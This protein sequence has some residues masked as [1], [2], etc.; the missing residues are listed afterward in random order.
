MIEAKF[1]LIPFSIF[2]D[3][4][5]P[6]ETEEDASWGHARAAHDPDDDWGSG[7]RY[8]GFPKGP[9]DSVL[10]VIE[11]SVVLE[12]GLHFDFWKIDSLEFLF[13]SQVQEGD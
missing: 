12:P 13:I 6:A 4:E 7:W 1:V 8:F 3:Y 2:A 10:V 9:P 5:R 11:W